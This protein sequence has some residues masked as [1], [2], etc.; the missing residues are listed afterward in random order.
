MDGLN[1][2]HSQFWFALASFACA[3]TAH[4]Q[5]A[6]P[7]APPII[8][9]GNPFSLKSPEAP[10]AQ[11]Y[12][13]G[14]PT[15][16]EQYYLELINR[17]RANPTAEGIRLA[18]TTDPNV[19]SAYNAF[20]VNLVLMQSQFVL[21]L[22]APPLSMN[23]TLMNAA[24]AHSQNMLQNNYQGHSGPD[25]S[26][27]TRLAGYTAGANGWSIGENVY[28]YSKSVWYGH[29]GFEVD[30]GGSAATGGMQSPPGHR[31]NIHSATFREVGVGVVLGS[32]GGS[33]GVG[34]QLVTQDF[35]TVGGLLPFVTGVVYRDL[36]NN[37]FY[38]PG[39]GLGGVT[40]TIAN[41]NSYAVTASSGGYSVPVPG[42]GNYTV[43]FSGGTAPTTQK[44]ASVVNG[45]NTKVDYIV[46]GS[47]TPTPTPSATPTVPPGPPT[48]ANI[49]TRAVVGP[50]ANVLIGG[51][52]VTGTESKRV[53]VRGV[54]PSLSLPGKMLN[55]TVELHDAAGATIAFNDNWGQSANSAAIAESGV[56]PADPNE[57][58]ILMD[59]A[60]GSYTAVLSGANLTTGIAVVE[61]YDLDSAADS[62]LA[63]ISTRV[64]VQAGD[65]AL[66]GGLIV[67]GQSPADVIVRAIGPSLSIPGAMVDP[68]LE[69]RDAS[70]ALVAS[71]DNWRSTQEAAITETGVAPT[72]DAESAI[73]TSLSPGSYTAIVRGANGTTGVAV[74]EVY[75]LN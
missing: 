11:L 10:A 14:D 71:N 7:P 20:G 37:G 8:S 19:L 55:P 59:L 13:I 41:V 2:R 54:G 63:N 52:I 57:A 51:F 65:S 45:Q 38:D 73:V 32:A 70:G 46:T 48:L 49:S 31:Q 5:V 74:V 75:Q 34:S 15:N 4:A 26:L 25:G 58:A 43:T 36:N 44:T 60:P 35:G 23:S 29:A 28:A 22:P 3:F 42:S 39:E 50:G 16:E 1:P 72:R 64:L 47:A 12:S 61:I 21:I 53:I 56:A 33:G 9:G 67:V 27:T 66:I 40:V 24:R 18:L 62:K 69:L 17:A 6:P 68:T 30:W